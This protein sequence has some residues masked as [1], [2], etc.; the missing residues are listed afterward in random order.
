MKTNAACRRLVPVLAIAL[1]SV[2][3]AE[4][5]VGLAAIVESAQRNAAL[6]EIITSAIP[7]L[8]FVSAGA[9]A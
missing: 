7:E 5:R 8:R 9:T 6:L 2:R 1:R 3:P 4:A